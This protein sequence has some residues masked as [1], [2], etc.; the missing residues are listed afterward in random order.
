MRHI[1]I[2]GIMVLAV[3]GMA[4]AQDFPK[5]ELFGGYSLLR[6]GGA[7]LDANVLDQAT[8][9]LPNTIYAVSSKYFRKG[10]TVSAVYNLKPYLGIELGYQYNYGNILDIYGNYPTTPDVAAGNMKFVS[11]NGMLRTTELALLAGPRFAYRK[12]ARVT[13]FAHALIGA[14]RFRIKP[15]FAAPFADTSSIT[16][17]L[18]NNFNIGIGVMAGG[19]L[20]VKVNKLVSIRA[21]QA[22]YFRA[23]NKVWTNPK[24]ELH[25]SNM[26]LSFGAVL[27]LDSLRLRSK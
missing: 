27:H 5:I 4:A 1:L 16:M 20:D 18:P 8:V 26:K 21:I 9:N 19:G 2:A 17:N 6:L 7:D 10:G 13:P 14:N 12:Y 23:Y 22:D 15:S 11:A 24:S 25:L 3:A